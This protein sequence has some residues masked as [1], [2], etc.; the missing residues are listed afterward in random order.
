MV[1]L[2][3][4]G[5]RMRIGERAVGISIF[6]L[7]L[8]GLGA[9]AARAQQPP[10]PTDVSPINGETYYI[11]NQAD[12]LQIDLNSGSIAAGDHVLENAASFTSL[13]QRWATTRLA[14]GNWKISNLLNGLCLDSA[15]ASGVTWTVQNLCAGSTPSQEWSLHATSNGY[16]TV[17]N[18]STG[19]V[20]DVYQGSTT[21]GAQL[22]QTTLSGAATQTQQWLLRPA[23][24]RG[25]DNALLEK[26]ETA[27][28]AASVTW[29][30]D[31][32]TPT[33]VLQLMKNHGVNM[34]RLRPTS[35]PPY[36][37]QASS[38][39]CVQNLCYAE[40]DAQDLDLAK[41]AKNLGMSVELTLFFD[42]G[43]SQSTP[44]AWTNDSFS[45]LQTDLYNYVL[46][47]IESYRS[48]GVMPDLVSI[49][50]E[51][52]TGFLNGN[53]PGA[54]FSN[55]AQLQI[56][57]MNAVRAAAADTSLGA[58]L[59]PP[60]VCIHI[61]PAWDLTSFFTEANT[62]SI[63]YDAICQSYYPLYHG[64]LTAAQAAAT[65]PSSQ[66]I[67]QSVLNKAASMIA[68]PI[69]IIEAGEHYENGFGSNDPWY[70]PPSVPGQRQFLIDLDAVLRAVPSNL[71]MGMEYWDPAGV[72][73]PATGG[74]F[75]NGDNLPNAVYAWNGLTIFD[76][77]DTSGT[78]NA[79]DPN[80]SAVLP[81]EDALGGKFDPSLTYKLV[82][83][84]TGNVLESAQGSAASGA[85]LD[86]AADSGGEALYQ[87]W[88]ISS[89]GDGYFRITSAAP[90][91]SGAPNA[92][93]DS[94]ASKNA[95]SAVVQSASSTAQEQEWDVVTAGAGYFNIVNHAS[96]LNLDL[97]TSTGLAIQ[98]TPSSS[99]LTQ[100]WQI[101]PVHITAGGASGFLASPDPATVAVP[102][103]SQGTVAITLTPLGG[104]SGS[105]TFACSGLP[106]NATCS[107]S[108]TS[109]TFDGK[110]TPQMTNVTITTQG[111][112]A[113]VAPK[114][115]RWQTPASIKRLTPLAALFL[116]LVLV[117]SLATLARLRFA[118]ARTL[119]LAAILG[120]A[121][122]AASCGGGG[123][124]GGPPPPPPPP[125][126]TPVGEAMI[127]VTV[128][129]TGSGGSSN[130]T[131]SAA[132][133]LNVTQ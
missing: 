75:I 130:A 86:T 95:G 109:V 99:S 108:P 83:R 34:V 18:Q 81:A 78:T 52:D 57:G 45:Q 3:A 10:P 97:N 113:L 104:Y 12:G 63:P 1:H 117:G 33:D 119:A 15:A 112:S 38:G 30:K 89:N 100:Q 60:L 31:A 25:I 17:Q 116:L 94:G 111:A 28:L 2:R 98:Q 131:Q 133:L 118:T 123:Y 48:A 68:K 53:D 59:P 67:E 26:Q 121:V 62:N 70:S 32:G 6:V 128:T 92:L 107:F 129:A 35:M 72:N 42:G 40:T 7:F 101:V 87:Q 49:G 50:N 96:A 54:N 16:Y 51:V 125:T 80:Y 90:P 114:P 4:R 27:R 126:P 21:A 132:I 110:D 115:S 77:A 124:G 46:Q 102:Q 91:Q 13:S 44:A 79:N 36:A 56:Q 66:P 55:F 127:T 8:C 5:K 61:T 43:S 24:F 37:T 73:I 69:F 106:T 103:G 84:S 58:P 39:P 88:T 120:C 122:L 65:N 41:R 19:L 76:N 85:S 82:N 9:A 71:A 11:I 47:E 74:G 22:D 23:F 93:D 14:D 20:L 64:P 105:A 29:W